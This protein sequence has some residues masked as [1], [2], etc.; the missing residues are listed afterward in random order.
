M[1]A[2]MP[3]FDSFFGNTL[4]D[5]RDASPQPFR[6]FYVSMSIASTYLLPLLTM[7][8]LFVIF[9]LIYCNFPECKVPFKNFASF[10]YCFFLG[11]ISFAV[12]ACVQGAFLNFSK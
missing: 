8:S 1:I 9:G 11:G 6:L 4:S 10:V 12:A 5:F 3:W 7:A 2:D